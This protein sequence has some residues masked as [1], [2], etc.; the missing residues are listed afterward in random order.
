MTITADDIAGLVQ[1]HYDELPLKRKPV[2][3]G[4]G[5]REWVPL[6]GIVA[7]GENDELWCLSLATGMKCLP[8]SKIPEAQGNILHDWH[9][10]VL[11]VRAFNRFILEECRALTQGGS[12]KFLRR[13][14]SEEIASSNNTDVDRGE[15][16]SEWHGQ[17]FTWKEDVLLHMYCS[18]APCGDASME[19]IM[20]SQEDATPWAL[21][22]ETPPSNSTTSSP[23]PTS[24]TTS[25]PGRA[26]FSQLGVVRRK[27][28]RS[29]AIPT[30]SKSCSDKLA[31]HQVTSLLS[32]T[33]ALLVDPSHVYL[34]S[35]VLPESRYSEAACLRA[36]SSSPGGRMRSLANST[37]GGGYAFHPFTAATTT[38][39]FR[40]SQ[41]SVNL[42]L[43]VTE[44]AHGHDAKKKAAAGI[45]PSNLAVAWTSSGLVEST[46]GGVLQGRK[47]SAGVKG[48]SFASRREI[49]SLANNIASSLSCSPIPEEPAARGVE[50]EEA[51]GNVEAIADI[52]DVFEGIRKALNS[53]TYGEMKASML[54]E[55][56]RRAKE[57]AR[58]EALKGWVR[59][60]GDE[61]F[62][63]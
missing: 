36:F 59:N 57:E 15:G 39:E 44:D 37:L 18:E 21:P 25:L 47:Q 7:Q 35:L 4:N 8:V 62:T 52:S 56:R 29:D 17:P 34:H 40:F 5:L 6:A 43:I 49:W 16:Q 30:L 11:A 58:A 32:S 24:P 41:R 20:A 48:A 45:A 38:S 51:E 54:L 42:E 13:R 12:S 60:L 50:G 46:L 9:A 31:L 22:P 55:A 33:T 63:L 53:K 3:R 27:P 10:E 28:A 19:L 14:T 61:S 23:T 2:L 26:Y 1:K